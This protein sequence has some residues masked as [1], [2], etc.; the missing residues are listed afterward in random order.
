[1]DKRGQEPVYDLLLW[2]PIGLLQKL[3]TVVS[4][5]LNVYSVRLICIHHE[6]HKSGPCLSWVLE[7]YTPIVIAQHCFS[8][9]FRLKILFYSPGLVQNTKWFWYCW[10]ENEKIIC[11]LQTTRSWI[12]WNTKLILPIPVE[13]DFLYKLNYIHHC[14][15]YL[16]F[17]LKVIKSESWEVRARF[18]TIFEIPALYCLQGTEEKFKVIG[19]PWLGNSLDFYFTV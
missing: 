11:I 1:M 18:H 16:V 6:P 10:L 19:H 7:L 4:L 9:D 17:S 12:I 14:L 13:F 15:I 8:R 5:I 2:I 3:Q